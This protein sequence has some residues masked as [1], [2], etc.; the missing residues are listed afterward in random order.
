MQ[1]TG[2]IKILFDQNR[3]LGLSQVGA[4]DPLSGLPTNRESVKAI[5]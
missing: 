4:G 2:K 5:S 1:S 3:K